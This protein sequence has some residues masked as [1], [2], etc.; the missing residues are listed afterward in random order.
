MSHQ[1]EIKLISKNLFKSLI[2][3]SSY[4][5]RLYESV[6]IDL[7]QRYTGSL[8]GIFWAF[9]FPF[10]QLS[11]LAGL[12]TVIFKVRPS[13][14]GQWEYVLLVFSGLVPLLTFSA[15]VTACS[16]SLTAN[17]NLLL[18][19]IFPAELIPMRSALSAHVPGL[20][21]LFIT[22]ILG[23]ILGK[24]SWQT[25][26]LVPAFWIL[27]MM[28]AIGV[29]WILSLFSLVIKDI[30][31]GIGLILMLMTILSPFAFTPEMVPE[32]LKFIIYLNPLSYFVLSFQQIIAY[33]AWPDFISVTGSIILGL[34][35][36][37]L[38]YYV[39]LKGKFEFFDYV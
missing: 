14:L 37:L 34:G 22:L 8:L 19:T 1:K 38:G 33:G 4:R 10:L 3:L 21:G 29:G 11:I 18:N 16:S 32:T 17:K 7:K 28:F 6:L 2:N 23:I 20:S 15:A 30:Q 35:F 25:I 27:L 5:S 13:G 39:F 9:L 24:L 26:I 31:H 36:F 12:Y